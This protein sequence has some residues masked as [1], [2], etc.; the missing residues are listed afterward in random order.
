MPDFVPTISLAELAVGQVRAVDV[1]GTAVALARTSD[2]VFALKDQCSHQDV[3]LSEGDVVDCSLECWLH[4]SAFDLRTG[5]PLG[6]P[7]VTPVPTFEVRIIGEA[8]AAMI[9]V[10]A[11][12][13][14][15]GS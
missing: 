12:S 10:A 3:A 6:P 9:H 11:T 13:H 8:D 4:G 2:G 14:P 7:A 5:E 1:R 15:D